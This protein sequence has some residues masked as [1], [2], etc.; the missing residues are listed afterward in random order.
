MASIE[1]QLRTLILQIETAE[2]EGS[3][4]AGMV[5][6]AL[7]LAR[8]LTKAVSD[9]LDTL[10]AAVDNLP[11]QEDDS[12]EVTITDP[13]GNVGLKVDQN[14]VNARVY[15]ICNADGDV[16]GTL[17]LSLLT[18]LLSKQDALVSG[19]NLSTIN[20]L[21]LL[22]RANINIPPGLEEIDADNDDELTIY[23][24]NGDVV[25]SINS[26]GL[27]ARKY[28]VCD[29]EGN[30]LFSIDE[31]FADGIVEKSV[32][33]VGDST[34][35]DI[36]WPFFINWSYLNGVKGIMQVF[37]GQQ[38]PSL[39]MHIGA[40]AI[41]LTQSVTIPAAAGSVVALSVAPGLQSADGGPLPMNAFSSFNDD[42]NYGKKGMNPVTLN[43]VAGTLSGPADGFATMCWY[44]ASK[45]KIIAYDGTTANYGNG[46]TWNPGLV[47][48]GYKYVRVAINARN[49]T[50][51]AN[52]SVHLD[53]DGVGVTLKPSITIANK[54]L[55]S[56]GEVIDAPG[57][58]L[59][60]Y[61][62][63]TSYLGNLSSSYP[64]VYN[65]GIGTAQPYFTR[66]AAGSAVTVEKGG[67]IMSGLFKQLARKHA[68]IFYLN[69]ADRNVKGATIAEKIL[70]QASPILEYARDGRFLY[71]TSH[72]CY[73]DYTE[74]EIDAIDDLMTQKFGPRYINMWRYL[75]TCGIADAIRF[76]VLT[77]S[78]VSGYT[79]QQVFLTGSDGSIGGA[80][81]VHENWYGAYMI[82]RKMIE[83]GAAL[84]FWN[85]GTIDWASLYHSKSVY[86]E[87]KP[88]Y[89]N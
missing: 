29:D 19:R 66:S 18:S 34:S 9:N 61:I 20:G 60:D 38:A 63:I 21:S 28:N 24:K 76:G 71:V 5:A 84:G 56:Q 68:M 39:G 51:V 52:S 73:V 57:F 79:W 59:S 25:L 10:S 2:E 48:D 78:Q 31:N 36:N 16:V 83:T 14:G 32:L 88:W 13:L 11:I 54:A 8:R 81:N 26:V 37:G 45:A 15:N 6:R 50:D 80:V 85:V 4:T 3:I 77:S 40:T 17:N 87:W 53:I 65:D 7:D 69:N 64:P 41:K 58:Y 82:F 33:L 62:D 42:D 86:S 67:C 1:D 89:K 47:V 72:Y 74:E 70:N 27:N 35:N 75:S 30:V 49:T 23:D 55:N 43:G 22:N 46:Y 12:G 44:N